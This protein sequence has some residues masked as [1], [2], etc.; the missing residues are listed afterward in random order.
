MTGLSFP[1]D[2]YY[3]SNIMEGETISRSGTWW[4]AILVIEDPRSHKPFIAAYKW[5]RRGNTWKKSTSYKINSKKDLRKIV[6][7]LRDLERFMV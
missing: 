5:Q 2:E 1:I 6:E 3:R 4:S 7:A